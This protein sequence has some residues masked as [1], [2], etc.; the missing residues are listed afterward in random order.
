MSNHSAALPE[1]YPLYFK[2]DPKLIRQIKLTLSANLSFPK[3]IPIMIPF[4]PK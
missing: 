1:G 4:V 3:S 2:G